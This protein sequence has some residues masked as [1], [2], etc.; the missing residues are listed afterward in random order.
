MLAATGTAAL[1]A[2]PL[3]N[4]SFPWHGAAWKSAYERCIGPSGATDREIPNICASLADAVAH[5]APGKAAQTRPV[6]PVARKPGKLEAA[7]LM[8]SMDDYEA[9]LA[10]DTRVFRSSAFVEKSGDVRHS[11]RVGKEELQVVAGCRAMPDEPDLCQSLIWRGRELLSDAYITI[12]GAFPPTGEPA[13]VNVTNYGGGQCCV[14]T[15]NIVDLTQPGPAV[16]PIPDIGVDLEFTLISPTMLVISGTDIDDTDE[17]GDPMVASYLYHL[18]GKLLISA[19]FDGKTDFSQVINAE[20]GLL[21]G[22]PALRKPLSDIL[23]GRLKEFR[24]HMAVSV[25]GMLINHRYLAETGCKAH[26]CNDAGGIYVIDIATGESLAAWFDR[27]GALQTAGSAP[28]DVDVS[29]MLNDWLDRAGFGD[30]R[31]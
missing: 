3:R 1:C 2:F 26:A 13:I 5:M 18:D 27:G 30:A 23:G 17:N 15:A 7:P 8:S 25:P 19:S 16:M 28:A 29:Q 20:P 14:P 22:D 6:L 31:E 10:R 11:L 4:T 24:Q 12:I 9:L 21:L